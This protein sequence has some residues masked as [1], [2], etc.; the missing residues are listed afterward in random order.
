L[1]A[2]VETLARLQAD[3]E[4]FLPP[5]LS[6]CKVLKL[7]D[8]LLHVAVPNAAVATR[9]RHSLPGL[10]KS[11]RERGWGVDTIKVNVKT[12]LEPRSSTQPY[13]HSSQLPEL[14]LQSFAELAHSIDVT[15]RNAALLGALD[16][17]LS[18]RRR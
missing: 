11:L 5:A 9:L 12:I 6:S 18:K 10:T 17:L 13:E 7:H 16:K 14:A 1:L 4:R 15:P 8:N 2:T 3:C